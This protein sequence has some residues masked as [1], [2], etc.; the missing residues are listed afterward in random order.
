MTCLAL[1]LLIRYSCKLAF[2]GKNLKILRYRFQSKIACLHSS[3][4]HGFFGLGLDFGIVSLPI[5]QSLSIKVQLETFSK[6]VLKK[7][8]HTEVSKKVPISPVKLPLWRSVVW[9]MI[10]AFIN[11]R[12]VFTTMKI[13][14]QPPCKMHEKSRRAHGEISSCQ[15]TCCWM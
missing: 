5:S 15:R 4:N 14:L 11:D 8:F 10:M 3:E 1:A 7:G 2:D 13:F 12:E 9:R 6:I